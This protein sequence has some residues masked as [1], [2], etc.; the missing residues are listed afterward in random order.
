MLWQLI[1]PLV[2][3]LT[4]IPVRRR[5]AAFVSATHRPQEVHE[6]LLRRIL[7]AQKD[8]DFGRRHHFADIRR[9]A[10]FR[11]QLPVATYEYFE[12]YI[13]RVARGESQALL[14]DPHVRMFAM[15]SGTTAVRKLIPVTRQYLAD[16]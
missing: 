13:Q 14:S 11:R 5:L 2:Y 1:R 10:D 7:A 16:Y 3:G 6:D 12:P 4:S 9:V 15:T 8:T